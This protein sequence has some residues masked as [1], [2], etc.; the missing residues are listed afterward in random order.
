M[1][2][3]PS[4]RSGG[5]ELVIVAM[6]AVAQPIGAVGARDGDRSHDL[7]H[8]AALAEQVPPFGH[9]APDADRVAVELERAWVDLRTIGPGDRRLGRDD[10]Q[11][12]DPPGRAFDDLETP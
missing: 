2:R 3:R 10:V 4:D 6:D 5:H 9:P 11:E 7:A 8:L 1:S 12:V